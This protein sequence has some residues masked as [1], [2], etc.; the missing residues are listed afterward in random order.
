VSKCAW[1]PCLFDVGVAAWLEARDCLQES[2]KSRIII[3]SGRL[4]DNTVVVILGR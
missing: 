2:E 3:A 1:S 4:G